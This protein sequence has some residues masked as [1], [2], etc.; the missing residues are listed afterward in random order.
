VCEKTFFARFVSP[1]IDIPAEYA[2]KHAERRATTNKQIKQGD[3]E[4][5]AYLI[6]GEEVQESTQIQ[7]AVELHTYEPIVSTHKTCKTLRANIT[8]CF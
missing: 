7:A 3:H 8:R 1:C 4:P 2:E 6:N 5:Q